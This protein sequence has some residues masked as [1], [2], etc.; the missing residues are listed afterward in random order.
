MGSGW[1]R[2]RATA[3]I[4]ARGRA[5]L[6]AQQRRY[7]LQRT[8]TGTVE[9]GTLRRL[10]PV[11]G[12]FGLDRGQPVDRYYIEQFLSAHA[13]DVRGRVL[14][15]G[16]DAYTRAFGGGGLERSDVLHLTPGNRQ[17]TIV[18]DLTRADHIP[19]AAFDCILLTQTLQMIYE[20]REALRHL[21]RI[22][23]PG[24]VLLLT[25]HGISRIGRREGVDPWGEYW[26]FT[27]QSLQRLLAER[28]PSAELRIEVYGNVLT[29]TAFLHG[30]A[31]EELTREELDHRDPDYELLIGV[32]A[33]KPA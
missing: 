28:F 10:A 15:V 24:G 3:A 14:E 18:G 25:T 30:L 9:F 16:D 8:R 31:A 13:S 4:P 12:V 5:W 29:A 17:A 22:L 11:S 20:V 26:H 1:L 27:S 21:H 2:G 7:R 6:R 32:R 23:A 19:A 33:R